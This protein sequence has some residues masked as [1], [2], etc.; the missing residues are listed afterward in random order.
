[1]RSIASLTHPIHRKSNKFVLCTSIWS[2]CVQRSLAEE[3]VI[4]AAFLSSITS[5]DVHHHIFGAC[6]GLLEHWAIFFSS[7]NMICWGRARCCWVLVWCCSISDANHSKCGGGGNTLH[8]EIHCHPLSFIIYYSHQLTSFLHI[9]KHF[10]ITHGATTLIIG[11][12]W[13][14][15]CLVKGERWI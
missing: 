7:K 9:T 6:G 14:R 4:M 10:S 15:T 3:F 13:Q 8:V 2:R 5:H 1:M 11:S 12:F